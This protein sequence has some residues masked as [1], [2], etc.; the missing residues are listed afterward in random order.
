MSKWKLNEDSTGVLTLE[1]SGDAWSEALDN[2]YEKNKDSVK[3]DG[4]REGHVPKDVFLKKFGMDSLYSDAIDFLLEKNY[5]QALIDNKVEPVSYPEVAVEK[6]DEEGAVINLTVA[7]TPELTL[8]KY[9]ALEVEVPV[10]KVSDELVDA[11]I[12]KLRDQNV[13]MVIKEGS[14][15]NGDTAVINYAGYKGDVAFEGGTAENHPLEIGSGSFIPGFEEQVVGMKVDEEKDINLTFPE[16][17]H[18]EELAGADVVFKVKVNEIK[19]RHVPELNDEFV[20]ELEVEASTVA[21]LKALTKENLEKNFETQK[22]NSISDLLLSKV[23]ENS[24][25]VIPKQMIDTEVTRM[26]NDTAQQLQG[27]GISMEQYF[28]ITGT[29]EADLREQVKE[30]ASKRVLQMLTLEKLIA[31][32]KIDASDDEVQAEIEDM[33]KMYSMEVEALEQ[34]IGGREQVKYSVKAKKVFD[35]LKKT[36]KISEVEQAAE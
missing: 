30:D 2:A 32:L 27:Q 29:T 17:Y 25:V 9:E 5:S 3:V 34:A 20:S 36:A 8:G 7:I 35:E 26:I 16:E 22:N 31:E 6:V 14:V 11:E 15:E 21:E 12:E 10:T 24:D 23:A 4:F 19:T 28:Q 1:F 18:S 33:A 13:E